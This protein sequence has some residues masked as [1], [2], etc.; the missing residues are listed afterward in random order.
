MMAFRSTCERIAQFP[1]RK[2]HVLLSKLRSYIFTTRKALLM[3]PGGGAVF[4]KTILTVLLTGVFSAPS[5]SQ[6]W[7]ENFDIYPDGTI[8]AAPKWTSNPTDCDDGGNVNLGPGASQWGVWAGQFTVNDIEGAP[9]CPTFGGGGNDNSWLSEVINIA[10]ACNV[11]ISMDVTHVGTLECDSPGAPIFGCSGNTPPD[12]SHDQVVAQYSINGGAF[13]QFGY[14]CGSNGTGTLSIG[15][16][17]GNTLQIRFF[18]ANKA[19]AEFY[20]IDN[21]VVNGT[22]GIIPT[23]AQIGPLCEN[24]G[25][26]ALPSTSTNGITGSWNTG[27]TFNPA[28]QGGSTAT[29]TFTPNPG[30]CASNTTMSIMVNSLANI[31][32]TP[33]GPFCTTDPPVA[34]QTNP[35]G[36]SGNWSG[37]GVSANN[38]DPGVA[39]GNVT[40]TFTPSPGQC[41]AP[42]TLGVVVF[43][44]PNANS[45]TLVE[46]GIG[47]VAT[48]NLTANNNLINNLP[49]NIVGWFLDPNGNLPVPNPSSYTATNGSFVYAIVTNGN[50]NSIPGAVLLTV[51]T[52]TAPAITG[53]PSSLCQNAAPVNLP[54][55]QS[56]VDGQWTGPGVTNNTFNPSGQSGATTL[57]FVPLPGQCALSATVSITVTTP[58][59]P[60]ITGVQSQICQSDPPVAL[61][62]TQGGV[63]GNWSGPGVTNNN[64][65]PTGQSGLSALTF[66]PS[67]GQCAQPATFQVNVNEPAT[68]NITG[69]PATF[70]ET[71]TPFA[72]P[73]TQS[74]YAGNWSGPGVTNNS[75]NPAGQ[76]G[77]VALVFTPNN[78]NCVNTANYTVTVNAPATPQLGT[79]TLCQTSGPYN[80]SN[81]ADP[82]FP[83][84]VWSGPGVG[85]SNFNPA[86]QSGAVTL[87]FTPSAA[88]TN[89][90][91]TNITVNVPATPQLAQ[92]DICQNAPPL[93]LATLTD[94]NYPAGAWSGPGVNGNNFNPANQS[95]TVTLTFTPSAAC[96]QAA[97]TPAAVNS[98]PGFSNLLEGCDPATQTFVVTFGIT[99]GDP[100]TY[101]VNGS[102]VGG[103]SFTSAP[104]P[105]GTNYLFEIDDTNGCGPVPVSGSANCACLTDAGTMNPAGTPLQVCE[106]SDFTVVH[107]GNENIGPGDLLQFVLH[108]NAGA[109]LGNII[110]V[111]NSTTFPY[112]SGV[113]LGQTYYVSAVAGM[114]D[115][116]GNVDLNDPCLSVSQGVPVV[117]YFVTATFQNGGNICAED[118]LDLQIQLTGIGP[119]DLEYHI[120][121]PGVD[122]YDAL[123]GTPALTMLSICPA[124]LGVPS[125]TITVTLTGL[126]DSNGCSDISGTTLPSQTVTALPAPVI[127][128]SPTLCPG[129]SIVVNGTQFDEA[130]PSGTEIFIN[131]SYLGCDS[132]VNV[133]LN[134]LPAATFNLT[135]TLCTGSSI[136]VNGTVYNA[137]NPS[138]TE[139]LPNA[140]ANGCDSTIFVNLTFN[141]AVTN[142]LAQTL[143]PGGSVTVNG[144]VYNQANPS[145]SQTFPGGS[146]LG[147][148]SIVNVNL[149]FWPAANFNLTQML[150]TGGSI[151]VNGTVYNQTNPT[152]TEILPG[153]SVNGCDSTIFVNLSFTPSV[154]QNLFQTLCSGSSVTVNG[155]VYNQS[156]PSG[157]Q[158]F[159]GGSYLGCDSIVNVSLAFWPA[160]N[161]NL[162]QTLCTGG[163]ITVNGT[164]YNASNPTGT[165]ILPGP[166]VN[167]CDSTIFVNLSFN[168]SVTNNLSQTLCPGGSITVNGTVYNASNPSGSQTFPGGSYLGCDSIVNISLAF[169]PAAN[170]NLTQTLCTGGSVMVNGTLFNQNN[171]SGTVTIPGGSYTGCDS[172][173]NVSLSFWPAATFNLTQTFCTGGSITVNGTVYDENNPA[174][175]EILPNASVNGCDSTVFINLAFGEVIVDLA[176]VLCSGESIFINGTLYFSG[177]PTGSETF[178][179]GS[180]LGCDSTVNVSLS[181]FP[182][183]VGNFETTL[184]PGQ[185]VTVNGTVYDQSNPGGVE[186]I[187]GGSYTGCDSTVFVS[188]S[189]EGTLV[190]FAELISPNCKNGNDGSVVVNNITGGTPPYVVALDGAN[191]TPV[192]GFPL[193][194][195][196][197]EAG[198]HQL[199]LQDADGNFTLQEVLVPGPPEL[200]LELGD[201]L[202]IDLGESVTLSA[203]VSFPVAAWDWSPPDFLDCT[204]CGKP[205][206]QMPGRDITY[207][208]TATNASGCTVTD[209]VTIF[210]K[211]VRNVFVPNAFSPNGDGINDN[212]TVFAGVQVTKIKSFKLFD[213]WGNFMYEFY[214]LPP[215]D[216]ASG[217]DGTFKG[218]KMDVGVYVWFAELEFV[219]GEVLIFKGDVTLVR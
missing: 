164:V 152:G 181:Y 185:S 184:Q 79:V 42:V 95:G 74:G 132:T 6:I 148:D 211:K 122:I 37:Q 206:A 133:S 194:F 217:W 54:T 34:L 9:C 188:L 166:S 142:T 71:S 140:S 190:A 180:Y 63:T 77:S 90:A 155:T 144:T 111:S 97:T 2:F 102:P 175:T 88:C 179:G 119:F 135:Q 50:C 210:V 64:F 170:F 75:F 106:G 55:T 191:S 214:N 3:E 213:R 76:S 151:T 197:M 92:A 35:G 10:N 168:T 56:G 62:T 196:D 174:G 110:A 192:T 126:S 112:P 121:G 125:G 198:F 158:T 13:I 83:A 182:E 186:V 47:G 154:T 195:N 177:N 202:T 44:T 136:T 98:A 32:P 205:T 14:V 1:N 107:N 52:A 8:N 73:T 11:S 67:P 147:C 173:V 127:S 24:A 23:F 86:G 171:P 7:S 38:F 43:Q 216:V 105:S 17:T 115:G 117:F 78:T 129:G 159:P 31:N 193:T 19:N 93:D 70:C 41:A 33:I 187:A 84:G 99:G 212:L 208:L 45:T 59:T 131:G 29:I 26:V 118:C 66:T 85:V 160:A 89:P 48:F 189:F 172:I 101:T 169:W 114:D 161:F 201:D 130:N 116:M 183:A 219:D 146:Y 15:G 207:T 167:G 28:G 218:K 36:V 72:L 18:A 178:P 5:F 81:L 65:D 128:L 22:A 176:P 69:V 153:A 27:S 209:K 100:A 68:P 46:C 163:S 94:P 113:V 157:S 134:F 141:S 162:T 58:S 60:A 16:L 53:V 20:Y 39:G 123:I 49:G 21:I 149:S 30:Q 200:L 199:T 138:G 150:C 143:C 25:P 57:T 139:I 82:N 109:A 120:A 61:P 51:T 137:N 40:L 156:N 80:L 203:N 103:T 124:A 87:T 215:N 91:T 145:G 204:A 165:E 104:L 96:T 4:I 108:D 12:N